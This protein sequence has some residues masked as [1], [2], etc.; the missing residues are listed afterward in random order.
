M[1][2]LTRRTFLGL[3]A[4]TVGTT[5]FLILAAAAQ[6]G[7]GPLARFARYPARWHPAASD[8]AAFCPAM[9]D[10]TTADDQDTMEA[11]QSIEAELSK[12]SLT[13]VSENAARIADA[14]GEI[15]PGIAASARRLARARDV[16]AA[17][18]EF[19]RLTELF[20]RRSDEPDGDNE[21]AEDEVPA[22]RSL[23][24]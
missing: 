16:A 5:V 3:C 9:T 24:V 20:S 10:Q 8:A 13:K 14:F 22:G 23:E 18:R 11:Y 2:L 17:R 21:A 12:G 15:N 6:H 1:I 7:R 19:Q 4:L